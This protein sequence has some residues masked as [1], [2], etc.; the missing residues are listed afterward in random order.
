MSAP[1]A[2]G[3]RQLGRLVSVASIPTGLVLGFLDHANL[4]LAV[5]RATTLSI[6]VQL[7]Q[8]LTV[9]AVLAGALLGVLT[10]RRPAVAGYLARGV[11]EPSVGRARAMLLRARV[12][13]VTVG[14][15]LIGAG[16]SL[17]AAFF[18]ST[19]RAVAG[20]GMD[21]TTAGVS[22]A[23]AVAMLMLLVV[24]AALCLLAGRY[25]THRRWAR[26]LGLVGLWGYASCA[27]PTILISA[28]AMATVPATDLQ[29]QLVARLGMAGG[30]MAELIAAGCVVAAVLVLNHPGLR[31][32][33]RTEAV[34]VPA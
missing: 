4:L 13:L 10:L 19:R 5:D 11:T 24:P 27:L 20:G 23:I 32:Y 3:A 34:R 1:A 9:S 7:V 33:L 22:M 15:A 31:P 12:L 28:L 30:V 29:L 16:A 18:T 8:C 17:S 2:G 6:L 14:F 26:R 25:L 21:P